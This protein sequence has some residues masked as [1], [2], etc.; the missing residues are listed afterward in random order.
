MRGKNPYISSRE[1]SLDYIGYIGHEKGNVINS[2]RPFGVEIECFMDEDRDTVADNLLTG[3]GVCE[4]GSIEPS[5]GEDYEIVTPR[6]AGKAGENYIVETLN[7][8]H[9]MSAGV[10]ASCGLHV[11]FTAFDFL[12]D[13]QRGRKEKIKMLEEKA[14]LIKFYQD[15]VKMLEAELKQPNLNKY[16]EN[17]IKQNLA[18]ANDD[19]K[20]QLR[21]STIEA[22][23]FLP[24]LKERGIHIE[25]LKSLL[26][27]YLWG[28]NIIY[29]MLPK[30]R[31]QNRYCRSL[32]TKITLQQILDI[33][34]MSQ[35]EKYW[36]GLFNSKRNIAYK[37]KQKY[38][39]SRYYG[40]NLHSLFYRGTI[41]IRYHHGTLNCEKILNWIN[42][43][44]KMIDW[45]IKK[46]YCYV[47][48]LCRMSMRSND[49][50]K[51][52]E[53]FA[54]SLELS[55]EEKA[56]IINRVNCYK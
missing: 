37:K 53:L 4:D 31:G 1:V 21:N 23:R 54:N 42:L 36:Y 30:S 46:N 17:E 32:N 18:Y 20:N 2:L 27:T 45:A 14:R 39:D 9:S 41:E 5:H 10:N 48:D 35:L 50:M 16:S 6:L 33:E 29:A 25:K 8:L 47:A 52:V 15:K 7:Q 13:R 43:H 40:L 55:Q 19:L 24:Q 49:I 3:T 51:S 26:L 34:D 44:A 12:F 28:E 11:H 56:Y 38:D 22:R